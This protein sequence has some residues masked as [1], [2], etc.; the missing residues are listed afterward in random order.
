[1]IRFRWAVCQIG[2]IQ[3]LKCERKIVI[4]AL[5]NLPKTLDETY[6]RILAAVPEEE[7]VFVQHA[8]QWISYHNMLYEGQGICSAILLQAVDKSAASVGI[9][10][11]DRFYDSETLR[12]LCGCLINISLEESITVGETRFYSALTVSFAHYTVR[13]YLDSARVSES[14]TVYTTACKQS[15]RSNLVQITLSEAGNPEPNRLWEP[16]SSFLSPD[17]EDDKNHIFQEN[18]NSYSMMSAVFLLWFLPHEICQQ[19][20]LCDLAVELLDPSRNL[21]KYL[22]E[23]LYLMDDSL[24]LFKRGDQD[25]FLSRFW[26]IKWSTLPG[27]K[28]AAQLLNLF[29]LCCEYK[30]CI[31]LL[32]WFLRGKD[33]RNILRIQ[34]DFCIIYDTPRYQEDILCHFN[35]SVIEACAQFAKSAQ[36]EFMQL[37]D[38]ADEDLDPSQTLLLYLGSGSYTRNCGL[39]SNGPVVHLLRLG[40]NPNMA[41]HRITPLQIAV[42]HSDFENVSVLLESGANPDGT[43]DPQGILLEE[44]R[45][46]SHFDRLHGTSPLRICRNELFDEITG[47]MRAMCTEIQAVLL[48]YGAQDIVK[49]LNPVE[50]PV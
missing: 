29:L 48:R 1:M 2:A 22:Y 47:E 14:S 41:G 39:D 44:D 17:T 25:S 3:R 10:Q 40:A 46:M 49:P 6:D 35:G 13:E 33:M 37:L 34:L 12:E 18:F 31:P 43:G 45:F 24:D 21:S 9:Q 15:L 50:P 8:L 28:E 42:L 11:Q 27:K 32:K 16:S 19:D 4:K 36:A 23:A 7:Q 38:F 30:G 5:K 26:N 20:A